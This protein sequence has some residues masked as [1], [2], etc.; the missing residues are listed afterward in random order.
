LI[1]EETTMNHPSHDGQHF[2][3]RFESLLDSGRECTFAC[4]EKGRVDMDAMSERAR[5]R[6]LYVRA[7]IG[8]EF[9][10]PRVRPCTA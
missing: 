6:Y 8:R 5:N 1:A 10:L 9:S 2:E 7:V 3:L 4:D